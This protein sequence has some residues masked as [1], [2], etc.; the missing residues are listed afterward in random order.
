MK[1]TPIEVTP[2]VIPETYSSALAKAQALVKP[3]PAELKFHADR[4]ADLRLKAESN[5]IPPTQER[6][7]ALQLVELEALQKL[8]A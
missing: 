5:G 2:E 6:F 8:Y 1:D 4:L 7:F 3:T